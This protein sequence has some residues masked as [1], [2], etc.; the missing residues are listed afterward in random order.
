M[1]N[2]M[3][4]DEVKKLFFKL[5]NVEYLYE[6]YQYNTDAIVYQGTKMNLLKSL[7]STGGFSAEWFGSNGGNMYTNGVYTNY[8][9]GQT[10]EGCKYDKYGTILVKFRI[11]NGFKDFLIF[12][13]R[14]AIK[15]YGKDFSLK[16]QLKK[17]PPLYNMLLHS[18]GENGIE[19]L[20][21]TSENEH[22]TSTIAYTLIRY[23]GGTKSSTEYFN[24]LGIRG[25]IFYGRNDGPVAI[26]HNCEDIEVL[27]YVDVA[28]TPL[29]KG[30]PIPWKPIKFEKKD[31]G[32]NDIDHIQYFMA[33]F[34]NKYI[35]DKDTRSYNGEILVKNR[36]NGL[37]TFID[38]N[39]KAPLFDIDFYKANVFLASGKAR[40]KISS[41]DNWYYID[42][43]GN[44]YYN[45]N[46]TKPFS[47][48]ESYTTEIDWDEEDL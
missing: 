25:I 36:N 43:N 29:H 18:I 13:K 5:N 38:V 35:Y 48:L 33:Q 44:L 6:S 19:K 21:Y 15:C 11:K 46:D 34:G 1:I 47:D 37:W 22:Y 16:S 8:E 9:I 23:L 12:D 20:S 41:D 39:K 17:Y 31:K 32:E 14:M 40:I 2:T 3:W 10:I 30:E 42:K 27:G 7:I 24:S 45:E 4:Q 26:I 28:T